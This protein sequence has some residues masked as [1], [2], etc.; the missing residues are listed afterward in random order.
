M[1]K[2]NVIVQVQRTD[3][4]WKVNSLNQ[5]VILPSVCQKFKQ[6]KIRQAFCYTFVYNL[7]D[8]CYLLKSTTRGGCTAVILGCRKVKSRPCHK[9]Q[10]LED[11]LFPFTHCNYQ[12]FLQNTAISFYEISGKCNASKTAFP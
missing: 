3:S 2:Q 7:T 11:R 10:A 5:D 12:P 1:A 9:T 6:C 4:S 8:N